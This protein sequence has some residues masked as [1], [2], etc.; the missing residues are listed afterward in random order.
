MTV[1]D[2][3]SAARQ[4]RFGQRSLVT[5]ASEKERASGSS[6]AQA[7]RRPASAGSRGS[8]VPITPVEATAT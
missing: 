8:S 6:S 7:A 4:A 1:P 3:S 2:G 5:I